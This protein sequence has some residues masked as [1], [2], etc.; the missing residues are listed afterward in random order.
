[1]IIIKNIYYFYIE[2]TKDI[3][4]N[5]IKGCKKK[6]IIY[7][8]N[9]TKENIERLKSFKKQCNKKGFKLYIAN[10]LGI[11]RACKANGLYLSSYNQKIYLNKSLDL[12]GSA[13]NFSEIYQKIK[14]GCKTV[15]LSRLFK[16]SYNDNKKNLGVVKFNLIQ[17]KYSIDLI[18]LGGI[19]NSN[20]LKLNLVK[21]KGCAS[22]SG[23]KKK[24]TITSRLF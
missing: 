15:I 4:L 22:L 21:S 19:N 3:D 16:T 24:P 7:R 13:H 2:N 23:V 20:L 18:P 9:K 5:N 6:I 1:M 12:I 8:N 17:K 11:A 10:N 14:Q